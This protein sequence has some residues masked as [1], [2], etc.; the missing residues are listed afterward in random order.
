MTYNRIAL[1][2]IVKI[3]TPLNA[4]YLGMKV[5]EKKLNRLGNGN[6]RRIQKLKETVGEVKSSINNA[7]SILNDLLNFDKV[8]TY[9]IGCKLDLSTH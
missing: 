9:Y 7:V 8:G 4:A 1:D 5:L 3:R 6:E 2:E